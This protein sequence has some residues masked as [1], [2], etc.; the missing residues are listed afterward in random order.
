[1]TQLVTGRDAEV[2]AWMFDKSGCRP[3]QFS[4]AIGIADDA[5][6]LTGGFMFTGYNGSDV[7]VH[8]YGPG[9]L[10]MRVFRAIFFIAVKQFNVNRMTVRTRKASMSRGVLKL[11]AVY[12]GMVRRLY[13]PTD[14]DR[15]AGRQYAFFRE[16]MEQLAGIRG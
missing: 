8:F 15:H 3:M 1:M 9:A 7:E 4:M 5:G 12:E 11:G 13:G 16:R 14:E 2:A 6:E 10:K